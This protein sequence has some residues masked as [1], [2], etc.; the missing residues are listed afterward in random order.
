M[1]DRPLHQIILKFTHF[2]KIFIENASHFL[3]KI[4][5]TK[6]SA[7]SFDFST[8]KSLV[9]RLF[10]LSALGKIIICLAADDFP[11]RSLVF[12]TRFCLICLPANLARQ[13]LTP[14][15]GLAWSRASEKAWRPFPRI[16]YALGGGWLG[17]FRGKFPAT[18]SV[19]SRQGLWLALRRWLAPPPWAKPLPRWGL[20][21]AQKAAPFGRI[22]ATSEVFDSATS[23]RTDPPRSGP[24]APHS[25]GAQ[26]LRLW[27]F[28]F[29]ERRSRR[30]LREES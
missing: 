12:S 7:S 6:P 27:A 4:N 1:W 8:F 3:R 9:P 19:L 25:S 10:H 30:D 13:N 17:N 15:R 24:T 23:S 29:D 21:R 16:G 20:R 2:I 11:Q 18:S 28:L 14:F 22:R 26:R 5:I